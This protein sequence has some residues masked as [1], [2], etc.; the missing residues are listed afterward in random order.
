M[1]CQ[2]PFSPF[3][4]QIFDLKVNVGSIVFYVL[5]R[6]Q[7]LSSCLSSIPNPMTKNK[8]LSNLNRVL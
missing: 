5:H 3:Q 8:R 7:S 4:S 2:E 1:K 6:W